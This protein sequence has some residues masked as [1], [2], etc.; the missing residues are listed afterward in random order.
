MCS[1]WG[2]SRF[3]GPFLDKTSIFQKDL[4]KKVEFFCFPEL[5]FQATSKVDLNCVL[6]IFKS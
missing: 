4:K 1:H 3:V 5:I 2:R 6:Y